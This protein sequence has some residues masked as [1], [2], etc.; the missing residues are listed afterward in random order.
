M[1]QIEERIKELREELGRCYNSL[2]NT[3]ERIDE[4]SKELHFLVEELN[5]NPSNT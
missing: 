1:N 3:Y 2:E 4:L 5:E